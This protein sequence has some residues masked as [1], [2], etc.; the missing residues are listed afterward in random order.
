MKGDITAMKSIPFEKM[1][2]LR[3]PSQVQRQRVNRVIQE[4]LTPA[5]RQVLLAYYIQGLKIPQ[6]ARQMGRH[7]SSVSRMLRRAEKRLEQYLRY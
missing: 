7:K 5:Q 3:L 1:A 2:S 6:I 4:E